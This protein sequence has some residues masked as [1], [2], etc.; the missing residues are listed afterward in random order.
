MK[1]FIDDIA[2]FHAMYNLPTP[3]GPT[4]KH[5]PV[6][7]RMLQFK[8]IITDEVS[9]VQD[10]LASAGESELQDLTIMA[11]WL[12]DI[13]VYCASEMM[14]F[15]I[16]IDRTLKIIMDSNFSKLDADGLPIHKDGKVMKGPNYW[17]PEPKL[18]LMLANCQEF[19][20]I[21]GGE[22]D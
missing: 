14:R 7:G 16:P 17:K 8:K 4:T 15:G 5:L 1:E 11:D 6:Y 19:V 3:A 2:K 18:S 9:E 21:V 22:H 12:G 13:I 10:I 20:N